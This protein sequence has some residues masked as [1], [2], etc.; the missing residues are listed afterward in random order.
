MQPAPDRNGR[1][2][3]HVSSGPGPEPIE[4]QG[5][6]FIDVMDP[7]SGTCFGSTRSSSRCL[8]DGW[9]RDCRRHRQVGAGR[10]RDEPSA[11]EVSLG[12]HH[13]RGARL[14]R[15]EMP[16]RPRAGPRG[17]APA[18][19]PSAASSNDVAPRPGRRASAARA[20]SRSARRES[21]AAGRGPW[22]PREL[23][24]RAVA[25]PVEDV[26]LSPPGRSPAA[27]RRPAEQRR[28][29]VSLDLAI[30][31]RSAARNVKEAVARR[32]SCQPVVG[33]QASARRARDKPV[34]PVPSAASG[35]GRSEEAAPGTSPPHAR[36]RRWRRARARAPPRAEPGTGARV[37][38]GWPGGA[39]DRKPPVE[40][41]RR[42]W[43]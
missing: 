21:R 30:T 28:P 15:A 13:A 11:Q 27:R 34:K 37:C 2:I 19:P 4:D 10:A 39:G 17:V 16:K 24:L 43:S 18:A 33:A 29:D 36:P 25:E 6:R 14:H 20:G 5:A 22:G 38:A 8:R 32:R 1:T 31:S 40:L 35:A 23:R 26:A 12:D 42:R 7:D 3:D 41:P 9:E